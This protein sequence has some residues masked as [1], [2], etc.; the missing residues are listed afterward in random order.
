MR[1]SGIEVRRSARVDLLMSEPPFR[2]QEPAVSEVTL[3]TQ[4]SGVAINPVIVKWSERKIWIIYKLL[5]GD[6][7]RVTTVKPTGVELE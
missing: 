2:Q 4:N 1:R 5:I 3:V 7:S 6:P